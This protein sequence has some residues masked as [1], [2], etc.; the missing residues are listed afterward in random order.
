VHWAFS[1]VCAIFIFNVLLLTVEKGMVFVLAG[2]FSIYALFLL[3]LIAFFL[4]PLI[5]YKHGFT[6][7]FKKA[8]LLTLDNLGLI[9]CL[10]LLLALMFV[11]SFSLVFLIVLVYGALYIYFV[12]NGFEF[13]YGKYEANDGTITK[14]EAD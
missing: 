9:L 8:F 6:A 2:I 5:Y 10:S 14:K 7:I 4:H 1:L 12:D 11:I 13:I 3:W